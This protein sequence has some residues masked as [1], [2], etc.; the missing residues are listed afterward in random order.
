MYYDA[1]KIKEGVA[2]GIENF[3][4]LITDE[5]LK[6]E[7]NVIHGRMLVSLCAKLGSM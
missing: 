4:F 5:R 6:Q 7:L 3:K 1:G 2:S